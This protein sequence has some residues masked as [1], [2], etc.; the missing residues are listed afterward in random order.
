MANRLG[1]KSQIICAP[2]VKQRVVGHQGKDIESR[3][4]LLGLASFDDFIKPDVGTVRIRT[5]RVPLDHKFGAVASFHRVSLLCPQICRF[6][7]LYVHPNGVD[8][9]EP[10]NLVSA[11]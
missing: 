11:L 9:T 6:P 1:S 2:P 3:S 5:H 8:I 7:P 10:N 4:E